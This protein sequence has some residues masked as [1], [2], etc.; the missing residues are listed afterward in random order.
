MQLDRTKQRRAVLVT[1]VIFL[2]FVGF[3]L[4]VRPPQ[5]QAN[6]VGPSHEGRGDA[7][8]AR[9]NAELAER[10]WR[11]TELWRAP[12]A[13]ITEPVTTADRQ[14]FAEALAKRSERRAFEG[15]PPTIPHPVAQASGV[16][17]LAC[18]ASGADIAGRRAPVMSHEPFTMCTQCHVPETFALGVTADSAAATAANAFEGAPRAGDAYRFGPGSPPQTPHS[19]WMRPR[20]LSCHGEVGTPGLQTAHP[21]RLACEQ[22]HTSAGA[23][24]QMPMV[25][26]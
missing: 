22:C 25:A 12:P 4:G 19:V 10:P 13:A 16:E 15:A 21:E 11:K 6:I 17:C 18:H 2:A 24:N 23:A 26:P 5:G 1:A 3:W 7:P 20:C 9:S 14:A 8:A